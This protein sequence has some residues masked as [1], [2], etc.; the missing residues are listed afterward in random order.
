M[1]KFTISTK[2]NYPVEEVFTSFINI[3]K[4]DFNKFNEKNPIGAKYKREVSKSKNGSLYMVNEVTDYKLN[5]A[6]EVTGILA[7][8]TYVSKFEFNSIDVDT[9]EIILTES[10]KLHGIVNKIG[11]VFQM[12]TIKGKLKKKIN[13]VSKVLIESIEKNRRKKDNKK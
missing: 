5:K 2:I 11:F 13:N 1:S 4:K 12:V 7:N 3:S 6:Y 9:T 8:S 10:Q